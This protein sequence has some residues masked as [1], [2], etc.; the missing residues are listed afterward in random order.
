MD[1]SRAIAG[2][3]RLVS[4]WGDKV[5]I[6]RQ[7]RLGEA[8]D[9]AALASDLGVAKADVHGAQAITGVRDLRTLEPAALESAVRGAQELRR[10]DVAIIELGSPQ[11]DGSMVSLGAELEARGAQPRFLD[12]RRMQAEDGRLMYREPAEDGAWREIPMPEAAITRGVPARRTIALEEAGVHFANLPSTRELTLS[13]SLQAVAFAK[14]A[15]AHPATIP[16]LSTVD[17]VTDAARTV[18][19]PAVIKNNNGFGGQAV[20]IVKDEAELAQVA[21]KHFPEPKPQSMLV[22]QFVDVGSADDRL[23]V[24]RGVDGQARVISAHHRQGQGTDGLANGPEGSLYTRIPLDELDP[25][26]RQVAEAAADAGRLD[27]T[28]VD[29]VSAPGQP[30]MVLEVNGT[31]GVVEY[32]LPMPREEHNLPALADWL[33]FGQ[34]QG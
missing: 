31:P 25:A 23:T 24:G 2:G 10:T 17:E 29:V 22:Q 4:E 32:D 13:K 16:D 8:N 18:G 33:V 20:W 9:V 11:A 14:E 5:A 7:Q 28:G 30:P 19:F 3:Q 21:A 12:G 6:V 34:R 1:V 15:V 26:K 27:Y